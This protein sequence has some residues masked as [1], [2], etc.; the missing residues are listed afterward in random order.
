MTTASMT[1]TLVDA[2]G[3][4][5]EESLPAKYEVCPRCHG[6]GRHDNPAFCNGITASEWRD[7]WD[8]E[9]RE[10]YLSGRYDV[11][12]GVC[13]GERVVT[14]VDESRLTPEQRQDMDRYEKQLDESAALDRMYEAERRFGA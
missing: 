7:E 5:Y 2:N 12:C 1:V 6:A 13:N 11:T 10:G 8:E 9:S 3:D 14:V 4:G